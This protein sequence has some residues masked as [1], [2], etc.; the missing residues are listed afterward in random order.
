MA[1]RTLALLLAGVVA[2]TLPAT[3][4]AQIPG[5]GLASPGDT[6]LVDRVAAVVGDS[7]ILLSE[8]QEQVNAAAAQGQDVSPRQVLDQL[9]DEQVILQAAARDTT[10]TIPDEELENRVEQAISTT[11]GNFGTEAA[12]Q[13]ALEESGLTPATFRAMRR[14]QIRAQ[15]MQRLYLQRHLMS[16]PPV[17]ITETEMRQFYQDQRANLQTRP[18]AL[19]LRQV[20]VPVV[21]SDS[22]WARARTLADS[23]YEAIQGGADF[24]ELA[25]EYSQDPGSA[26]EGGDMGWFRRGNM[27]RE[28]EA[29]AFSL[30][31]GDVAPPV[32]TEFG[33]HVIRTDRVRPGEVKARHILIRP[34]IT[35]ADRQA[36]RA[37]AEEIASA[38]KAGEDMRDLVRTDEDADVDE[39]FEEYEVSR[40]QVAQLPYAGFAENLANA[41][42]GDVVGPFQTRDPQREYFA[43]V[44]VVRV[45]EAGEFTFEDL[46][47]QIRSTLTEQKKIQRILDRLRDA[48]YIDV[49]M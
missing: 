18:E 25:R 46:R 40:D 29:V 28:F 44:R 35:D 32:R 2:L 37:R 4:G 30:R 3:A 19:T 11:R 34:E 6:T 23:L 10:L 12:F 14:S 47:D 15:L 31:P 8:V 38:V 22:A 26:A 20:L 45:R 13:R 42:E 43:V 24:E 21:A 36:A 1:P 48:T 33:W 49:R 41:S 27:V 7:V 9:V 5:G 17:A 39:Q 16:A